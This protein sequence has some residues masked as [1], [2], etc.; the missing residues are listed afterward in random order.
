MAWTVGLVDFD[1]KSEVKDDGKC[2]STYMH[3]YLARTDSGTF[4]T[5]QAIA[6]AVGIVRGSIYASD[7]NAIC[8]S[9]QIGPGPTMTKAP[10]LAFHVSAEWSTDATL[11]EADDDD[12]TTNRTIWSI[13]PQIQSR[14]EIVDRHGDLIVNT[15]GSP[16]DGG[17]PCD[18]RLGTV[19]AQR[20]ID[21]AGY[22]KAAVLA[23]SGKLNSVSFLGGEPGTVQVDI[24]SDEK[25]EGAFH[26][27]EERFVFSYDPKGWQ[28]KPVSA[29]FFQK[30]DNGDLIRIVNGD[31]GDTNAP[32]DP[33]QEPEPLD[34]DGVLVPKDNRPAGCVFVEVDK[35]D[36][37]DF[38]DFNL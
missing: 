30:D 13:A 7:P 4:P 18:I 32:D 31:L 28:P 19:T 11:P 37:M 3:K 23:N 9:V 8:R 21:A 27:W 2:V 17:I 25:Y 1:F 16:F 38:A 34:I 10:W 20:K 29:G 26:F 36:T 15:A 14:Y 24:Y 33:V 12:P 22:D 5:P 35:F 6:A